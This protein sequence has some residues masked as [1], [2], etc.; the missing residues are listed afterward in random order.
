MKSD[1]KFVITSLIAVATGVAVLVL[2]LDIYKVENTEAIKHIYTVGVGAS[3]AMTVIFVSTVVYYIMDLIQYL[4]RKIRDRYAGSWEYEKVIDEGQIW[5]T[6][7]PPSN[8]CR[9]QG[10]SLYRNG[11]RYRL[12]VYFEHGSSSSITLGD[13]GTMEVS[14]FLKRYDWIPNPSEDQTSQFG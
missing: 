13:F 14:D 7:N 11:S 8:V 12:Y 3:V 1:M 4:Y 6:I 9:I 5:E 2:G 10:T